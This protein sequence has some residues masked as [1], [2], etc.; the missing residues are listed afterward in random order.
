M[1]VVV[2]NSALLK[3]LYD[4]RAVK[5]SYE[6]IRTIFSIGLW[7]EYTCNHRF[8]SKRKGLRGQCLTL[9][10]LIKKISVWLASWLIMNI[11]SDAL[12]LIS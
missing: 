3:I 2:L 7:K 10:L 5:H 1:D 12:F 9:F 4:C 6:R 8:M 11:F